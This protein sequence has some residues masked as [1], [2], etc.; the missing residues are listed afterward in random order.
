MD[1]I[2]Q[3]GMFNV[4]DSVSGF[5][6]DFVIRKNNEYRITE[7]E[8]RQLVDVM[9]LQI[10][11]VSVEDLLI[12]KIIWIQELQSAVQM[13]DI[14]NLSSLANLEWSYNHWIKKLNLNTFDLIK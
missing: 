8:R 6:A 11:G 3:Q 13:Q 5:K 1:A 9:G 10:Y 4:I 2:E 7:F 14:K 12:S